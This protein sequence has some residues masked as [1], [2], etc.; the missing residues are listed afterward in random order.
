MPVLPC[1]SL[2]VYGDDFPDERGTALTRLYGSD[3]RAF[4]GLHHWDLVRDP[5]VRA[6]IA[7]WLGVSS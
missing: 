2:V 1:P 4:P 5:Q 3:E 6:T 7:D